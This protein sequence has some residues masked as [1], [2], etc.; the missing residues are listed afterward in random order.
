M[1]PSLLKPRSLLTLV[2]E[3]RDALPWLRGVTSWYPR[4]KLGAVQFDIDRIE[5]ELAAEF[6][7]DTTRPLLEDLARLNAERD[8]LAR[9][10]AE[11]KVAA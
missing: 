3:G 4:V 7:V 8:L 1:M 2:S 6:A 10:L 9:K 11:Q 5:R